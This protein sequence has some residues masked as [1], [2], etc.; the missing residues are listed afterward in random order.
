MIRVTI[1]KEWV[2]L[3]FLIVTLG[4]FTLVLMMILAYQ[5]HTLFLSSEP[6]ALLWHRFVFFNAHPHGF[7]K[8]VYLC[9]GFS[10]A[11][12]QFYIERNRGRILVH[13]PINPWLTLGLHQ[14]VGL[15]IIIIFGSI[16]SIGLWLVF[17]EFYPD[18]LLHVSLY[19]NLWFLLGGCLAYLGGAALVMEPK[20]KILLLKALFIAASLGF[21]VSLETNE[22]LFLWF[23]VGF[24]CLLL[25][26]D[27]I[28][29]I[30]NKR[31]KTF[32][33]LIVLIFAVICWLGG[34]SL[35]E[36]AIPKRVH[37]YPFYST[38]LETFVYQRNLGGH[39]FEYGTIQG[40]KMSFKDF[41]VA[42]P[43][44]YW[45][46]L[47]IQG[48]LPITIKN[49]EFNANSIKKER[50]SLAYS[51]S[52]L[53]S[54]RIGLYPLFN[55]DPKVG[56]IPF[57]DVAIHIGTDRLRAY[58]HHGSIDESLTNE[59][60]NTLLEA[61][62]IFPAK[63]IWGKFTNLKP[64]D[65]G[66]FLQ[67]SKNKLY[68]LV[69]YG[70]VLHVS[71]IPTPEKLEYLH[72]SENARKQIAGFGIGESG[73]FY[74]LKQDGFEFVPLELPHFN[75]NTMDLQFLSDPLHN[76]VRYDDGKEYFIRIFSKNF[77]PLKFAKFNNDS[78][79]KEL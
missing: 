59:L 3:R 15:G 65:L 71:P 27:S 56:M 10:V 50:L 32:Y 23:V 51:P 17:M 76:I 73:Q 4:L 22:Y 68:R 78:Q 49:Q 25:G 6:E 28:L 39:N 9:L 44:V 19:D 14:L 62:F 21:F 18:V 72:I 52:L 74:I 63:N 61:K 46:D 42:L 57:P 41:K 36:K 12:A 37:Y 13:L 79:H 60:N 31:L 64:F 66:L 7:L 69:R 33:P 54:P 53:K 2:K 11:L 8:I 20:F 75:H 77:S 16:M 35:W 67:D 48:M 5:T 47:Q 1:L 58:H 29:A 70:D 30:S 34:T 24:I 45:R 55:P 26:I 38:P 40:E 43:F